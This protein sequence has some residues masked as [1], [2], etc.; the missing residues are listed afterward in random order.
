MRAAKRLRGCLGLAAA[1]AAL[2]LP[3][4]AQA[5]FG[6]QSISAKALNADG[7]V[8]LQAGSHP[9]EYKLNITMN[10][11]INGFPEGVLR[12][13]IVELPAGLVGNPQATPQ[14]AGA[15]FEGQASNCPQNSQ[16]GLAN[17]TFGGGIDGEFPVY[18]L[19]TP[20]GVPARIGFSLVN[21]NSFQEASLRSSDYGVSVVDRT[22]PDIELQ[23]L[24][25]T[26][27]GVPADSSHDGRRLCEG[28]VLPCP[29]DS[30]RRPFLTLPTSCGGPLKTV[31]RVDSV[32]NP[33]VF[34]TKVISS[35][36]DEGIEAGLYNCE[37][38]PFEPS[39][40]AQPETNAADSPTGLHVNVHLPQNEDPEGLAAAN[41][42]D[43]VV[44]LPRGLTV[45]ASAADGLGA[46]PL[47]GPE[48][49]NLP[50]STDPNVPEPAAVAEAAKCPANSKVGNVEVKTP[51][52]D[53]PVPGNLYLAKQGENPFSS[54]LAL[55]IALNDPVSGTVVKI[56]GKVEPDPATGQLTATFTE[57]PQLPFED[58]DLDVF[59]GPHANLTTPP[60]CGTYTTTA[61]LT[62]W[63][64]P[65]GA[66]AN[67]SSSFSVSSGAAGGPCAGSEAQLPNKPSLEAGTTMPFAGNYSPLLFRLTREN[68]SQRFGAVNATMPPGLTGKLAGLSECSD[69][70]I[71]IAASRSKEG[72]GTLEKASPSCPS[73]SEIGTVTVGAGSGAPLY[74]SG[75]AYLAGPYK[76]APISFAFIT[77][78]IAGPFDLG[79]VVVRAAAY[80]DPT[81]AQITVKS[82][83]IPQIIAGI[84]L[85]IRSIAVNADRNR[86]T[87]NP[88]SCDPMQIGASAISALSQSVL[89][90]NRFQ[91]GGC[92]GLD[93]KP[94]IALKLKGG[95]K[96]G[97]FPKL[98]ATYT[99]KPEGEANLKD[100]V[101]RFPRSEFVEQGHFRTICTRVQ[102]AANQCPNAS[103]YGHVKAITPL[104]DK[105]LQGPVY[106]RSSNHNLPDVVFVL[107]GQIDAQVAVRIDSLKGSLRAS[108]E[109]APDVPLSKVVLD[110]QGG[111]KGLLVNSR[112]V[113]AKA[114][115]A[116]A[117]M[118]AHS[119]REFEARPVV[120]S[121]CGGRKG[122][123]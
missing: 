114:Y 10:Q 85:D 6:L 79:T 24:T 64:T 116:I 20:V 80:V 76:G 19:S 82:D 2:I 17:F 69:A 89:L 118:T 31:V 101:L 44:T 15:A 102:F 88:T 57:N 49:I 47:E 22:I 67:R 36:D 81:T 104:L 74:V 123:R 120:K 99:P 66:T 83:Q 43:T 93:F 13:V 106:L 25:E 65:E 46:C 70:Q 103:I 94:K 97:A 90:S 73:S 12:E 60:T 58:L 96:R 117:K 4:T 34:D 40:S 112:D 52:L 9:Y 11:D 100:L 63:T 84:P 8:D 42:K 77:P 78:A 37:A 26:I 28:N 18:N 121:E 39:I 109:D 51:L 33:G 29:T 115:R 91:V 95:T 68:G 21:R 62:P 55:Y 32:G 35:V 59:G 92:K 122:K 71:A 86:F 110:M 41:L 50:K 111:K 61:A 3:A 48:G 72:Q 54:L 56:A 75:K 5:D 23:T 1:L 98:Q 53:H 14:C 30:P 107:K 27:W 105:P 108:L 119:G 7:S 113:C 45:N 38:P 87:L 16:I